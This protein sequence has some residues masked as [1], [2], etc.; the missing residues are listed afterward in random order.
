MLNLYYGSYPLVSFFFSLLLT[1]LV[2]FTLYLSQGIQFI[3]VSPYFYKLYLNF[4]TSLII[5]FA[6]T[7][8]TIVLYSLT[9][10]W[11]LISAHYSS[12]LNPLFIFPLIPSHSDSART[13]FKGHFQTLGN[14]LSIVIYLPPIRQV[15]PNAL[16]LSLPLLD[17]I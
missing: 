1:L 2:P 12:L 14:L 5:Q 4:G 15:P 9:T 11:D 10:W 7:T 17:Y 13:Y 3:N 16:L 6:S 8:R